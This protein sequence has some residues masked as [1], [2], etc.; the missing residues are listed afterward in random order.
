MSTA[1]LEVQ[2]IPEHLENNV[3]S[4]ANVHSGLLTLQNVQHLVK[5]SLAIE[6]KV[7]KFWIQPYSDGTL[8]FLGTHLRLHVEVETKNGKETLYFFVKVIPFEVPILAEYMIDRCVFAK[9]KTFYR[10]I[11]PKLYHGYKGESWMAICHFVKDHMLIFEDLSARGYSLR[12]KLFTKE[13]IVSGLSSIARLHACSLVAETRLGKSLK[14]M[15][16]NTFVESLYCE[17]EKARASHNVSVSAMVAIAEYIG[18]DGSAIP[19]ICDELFASLKS[20]S[21]KRNVVSHGDLWGNNLMFDN[22]SPPNCVLVDFQLLRYAPLAHDV[23]QFLYLCA[24]RSFRDAWEETM[25]KHYYSVLCE[26][27]NSMKPIV[28]VQVPPWSELIEGV[29]EQRIGSLITTAIYSQT[30]LLDKDM[31][32]KFMKDSDSYNQYIFLNRNDLVLDAMRNDLSYNKRL[33]GIIT[34]LVELS[35]R[36]EE[37]PKPT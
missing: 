21:T 37:L 10:D 19:R 17:N 13:L 15:Y 14:D 4:R 31:C 11:L 28:S 7:C 6:A 25:L 34:E 5:V 32:M 12:N 18:L 30:V 20:S 8:G 26:T 33:T 9:E 22:S 24:D 16:P 2:N 23:T 29:N 1:T 3:C 36:F 35:F 27:L